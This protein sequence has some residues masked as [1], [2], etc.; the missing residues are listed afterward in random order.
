VRGDAAALRSALQNLLGNAIKYAGEVRWVRVSAQRASPRSVRISV[1]DR[2]PG[3]PGAERQRIFE[4]FYRGHD[5]VSRQIP[6]SGLG[7]HIVRR[8]VESHGGSI[9]VTSEP[10]RGSTF[11][12]DLP[13]VISEAESGTACDA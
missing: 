13:G 7:L 2:G 8:I 4:P 9:E 3:I 5:A 11:S 12:I 6:G 1:T 10:G